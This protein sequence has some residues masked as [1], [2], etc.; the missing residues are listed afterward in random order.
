MMIAVYYPRLIRVAAVLA[1][2]VLLAG[3]MY[4]GGTERLQSPGGGRPAG[5]QGGFAGS[6]GGSGS[7]GN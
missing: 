4:L 2:L 1:F 5:G 7:Q 3:M 6:Q